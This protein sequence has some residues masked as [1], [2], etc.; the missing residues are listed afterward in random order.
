MDYKPHPNALA[1]GLQG[2]QSGSAQE[3]DSAFYERLLQELLGYG[4][5]IGGGAAGMT[6][7]SAGG[8]AGTAAG[9]LVG[10]APGA[11]TITNANNPN[12][13]DVW[14]HQYMQR[15]RRGY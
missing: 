5:G 4:I 1:R 14:A 11:A 6:I 8:P 9:G 2:T 10:V 12:I 3:S 15:L 13:Q 7:G